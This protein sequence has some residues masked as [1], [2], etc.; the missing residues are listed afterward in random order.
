MVSHGGLADDLVREHLTRRGEEKE[1]KEHSKQKGGAPQTPDQGTGAKAR[2]RGP[3][4]GERD[5]LGKAAKA[6]L[7]SRVMDKATR[8]PPC[9]GLIGSRYRRRVRKSPCHNNPEKQR[10]YLEIMMAKW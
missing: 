4:G 9:S 1:G 2:R 8:E 7:A 3:Q 5:P 6:T 10:K